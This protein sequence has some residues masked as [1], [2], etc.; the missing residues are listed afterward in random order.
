MAGER[1]LSG[2]GVRYPD[3]AT[4]VRAHGGPRGFDRGEPENVDLSGGL[5]S[6]DTG[7]GGTSYQDEE[8]YPDAGGALEHGSLSSYALASARRHRFGLPR[9]RL[10][11]GSSRPAI[12]IFGYSTHTDSAVF[13]I[14]ARTLVVDEVAEVHTAA[15]YAARLG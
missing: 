7:H 4:V 13:W 10:Y 11:T 5:L 3:R 9:L 8:I 12:G 14:A 1:G 2:G 15:V 6:W